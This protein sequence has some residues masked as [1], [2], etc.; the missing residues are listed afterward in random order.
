MVTTP[1]GFRTAVRNAIAAAL[2]TARQATVPVNWSGGAREFGD[3]RLLLD[4]V[5]EV[6]VY[7]REVLHPVAVLES[8]RDCTLQI[9][10]ESTYDTADSDA[11]DLLNDVRYGLRKPS[12][13]AALATAGIVQIGPTSAS[14]NVSFRSNQRLVSSHAFECLFRI[15]FGLTTDEAGGLIEHVEYA[16]TVDMPAESGT[17][18]IGPSQVD[19]PTPEP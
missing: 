12:V 8:V 5:S 11:L 16:G 17:V 2:P 18:Q 4:V 14:R 10:A 6:E 19:D 7:D 9:R 15:G 13:I 3:L 1:S